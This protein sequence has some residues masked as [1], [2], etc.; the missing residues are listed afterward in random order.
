MKSS[1]KKW[2][3]KIKKQREV[4]RAKKKCD[5]TTKKVNAER[6]LRVQKQTPTS[7]VSFISWQLKRFSFL[8]LCVILIPQFTLP[9]CCLFTTGKKNKNS[10]EIELAH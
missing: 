7:R 4:I 8:N 9:H 6:L 5:A 10:Y 2:K 1:Y 3:N